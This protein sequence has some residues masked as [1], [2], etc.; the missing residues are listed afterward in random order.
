VFFTVASGRP[1]AALSGLQVSVGI[2]NIKDIIAD[3][4]EVLKVVPCVKLGRINIDTADSCLL[5]KNVE[6]G[7][8]CKHPKLGDCAE[9]DGSMEEQPGYL[10][11]RDVCHRV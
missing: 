11:R 4:E 3:F 5:H 10:G 9:Q 7:K 6:Q 2:E 1:L 8:K